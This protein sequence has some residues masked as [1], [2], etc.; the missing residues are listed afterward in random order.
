MAIIPVPTP[1]VGKALVSNELSS[2][3]ITVG[4][5]VPAGK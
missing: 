2:K 3:G 1:D 4:F 5:T